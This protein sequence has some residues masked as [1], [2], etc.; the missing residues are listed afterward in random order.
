M[1]GNFLRV[2]FPAEGVN[3]TLDKRLQRGSMFYL[4]QSKDRESRYLRRTIREY[5]EEEVSG[6]DQTRKMFLLYLKNDHG[7]YH[8]PCQ[9]RGAFRARG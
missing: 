4:K 6:C 7:T 3:R 2:R 8:G 9:K 1:L 5:K